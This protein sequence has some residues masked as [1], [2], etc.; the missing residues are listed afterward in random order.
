MKNQILKIKNI[1]ANEN[2]LAGRIVTVSTDDTSIRNLDRVM[3]ETG[4]DV[5]V[6]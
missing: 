2:Q 4:A 6:F 1:E 3:E 5:L